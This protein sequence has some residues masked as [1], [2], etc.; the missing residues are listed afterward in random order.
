MEN[1]STV[2][3]KADIN[4]GIFIVC[5]I[6]VPIIA[7]CVFYIY[8]N[9]SALLLAFQKPLNDGTG[10]V[11]WGF[12]QFELFFQQLSRTSAD[13]DVD[14]LLYLRNTFIFFATDNL[15]RMPL[16]L[17]ITYFVFKKI[18]FAKAIRAIIFL[19]N[20]IT[21]TIF[22]VLYKYM[23]TYGGPLH[24]MYK[25]SGAAMPNLL[26]NNDTALITILIFQLYTGLGGNFII[27]G[28][29]MNT[30]NDS[31][32]EAAKLDGCGPFRELISIVIPTIW[33]TLA[34]IILMNSVGILGASGPL[35]FFTKGQYNTM[36]LGYWI[37]TMSSSEFGG[38]GV[39]YEY[40]SA[41]GLIMT[42][43]TLPIVF[44]V[45]KITSVTQ[46]D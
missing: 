16:S 10:K 32:I 46:E 19:P 2:Q 31:M 45:K 42:V 27:F 44:T 40:A 29:A 24:A 43:I 1:T 22:A 41:I 28:G 14:I 17:I 39:N 25:A 30:I 15:V 3:K 13:S 34:T 37:S 20:I 4:K 26:R 9:A 36:S 5:G 21:G 38:T 6:I 33:P 18:L 12:I 8:I 7:F 11:E 35:L 23:I